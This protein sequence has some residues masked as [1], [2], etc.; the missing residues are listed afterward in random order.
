MKNKKI[1][2]FSILLSFFLFAGGLVL[3]QETNKK[4]DKSQGVVNSNQT[5]NEEKNRERNIPDNNLNN[6]TST[7]LENST[8][9]LITTS[10]EVVN[11]SSNT[12]SNS[13]N[14][15]GKD[16]AISR[17][18]EVAN[19]VSEILQ[20]AERNG[21]IGEQVRIIAQNQE[22]NQEKIETH[23][24]KIQNRNRLAKFLF[25]PN[26]QEIKAI[27]NI[28]DENKNE[29]T[30]LEQLKNKIP[31]NIDREKIAEQI[32]KLQDIRQDLEKRTKQ[33]EKVFSLFGWALKLFSE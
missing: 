25:G 10:S 19:A 20:V 7:L 14:L 1:I 24:E 9:T 17:R 22:K 15:K 13:N 5:R 2:F 16:L 32:E 21:G 18:S 33:S 6:A 3:A 27:K 28:L 29:L 30:E 23:L 11:T 26:K 8:S 12:S 4:N 31:E